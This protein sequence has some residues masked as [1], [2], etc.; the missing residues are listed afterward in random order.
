M[1]AE[2]IMPD[3]FPADTRVRKFLEAVIAFLICGILA[4]AYVVISKGGNLSSSSDYATAILDLTKNLIPNVMA[5]VVIFLALH[6]YNN[7]VDRYAAGK[8]SLQERTNV[9]IANPDPP[10]LLNAPMKALSDHLD[11]AGFVA[12]LDGEDV[13]RFHVIAITGRVTVSSLL[14]AIEHSSLANRTIEC[15]LLLRSPLSGDKKWADAYAATQAELRRYQ[16]RHQT[17]RAETRTYASAT[18]LHCV[19]AEFRDDRYS[20]FLAF[21]DW[22]SLNWREGTSNYASVVRRQDRNYQPLG[23]YLSWFEHF[24][25]RHKVHTLL[26]DFDDTLFLTT[27]AQVSAWVDTIIWAIDKKIIRYEDLRDNIRSAFRSKRNSMQVMTEVFLREQD[28][29]N[30]FRSIF[31]IDVGED[32]RN[33]IR[34]ARV[35]KR[36]ELTELHA[37][38]I[39]GI[40][41]DIENLRSEYQLV[42]VSATSESLINRILEKHGI[43]VVFS[44]VLGR[45]ALTRKW[46]FVENKAQ[47]FIGVSNMLGVPLE[48]MIFIGDSDAD[49]RAA[50]QLGLHFIENRH[51]AERHGRRSLGEGA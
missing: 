51:N 46:Q 29:E 36:E 19:I 47:H 11:I 23:M 45:E 28:E 2:T 10:P 35:A 48:R 31:E 20:A 41:H 40:I 49:Y 21:Y 5:V 25:G 27:S 18:P 39:V 32:T 8:Q 3:L 15:R 14:N 26:F 7:R 43:D 30:I 4:V 50:A 34:T 22:T 17:F 16:S 37:T 42:I 9:A 12:S 6:W 13:I 38:P 33:I 24:W 1:T 44:F